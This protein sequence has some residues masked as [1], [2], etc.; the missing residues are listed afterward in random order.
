[1]TAGN[2][3][4]PCNGLAA[5]SEEIFLVG[6]ERRIHGF[7]H[8]FDSTAECARVEPVR[9]RTVGQEL[10][11][12]VQGRHDRDAFVAHDLAGVAHLAQLAVEVVDRGEQLLLLALGACDAEL[13]PEQADRKRALLARLRLAHVSVSGICLSRASMRVR[14]AASFSARRELSSVRAANCCRSSRFS[15]R[16]A[17]RRWTNCP[18]FSSRPAS[19]ESISARY[20]KSRDASISNG[21]F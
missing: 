21:A 1:N 20:W 12:D 10:V 19:S 6:G 18:S 3:A 8:R 16:K 17:L 15:A 7:L 14:A 13:A 2:P 9:I 4:S 11:R 5:A